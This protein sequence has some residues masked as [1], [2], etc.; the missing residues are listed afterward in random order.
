[1]SFIHITARNSLFV[2]MSTRRLLRITS[3]PEKLPN[4]RP[5]VCGLWATLRPSFEL[6]V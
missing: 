5:S 2:P 6:H 3:S 4:Y 1:M